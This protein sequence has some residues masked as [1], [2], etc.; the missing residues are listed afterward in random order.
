MMRDSH[1]KALV[2]P[3]N[4][5]KQVAKANR[6]KLA[7]HSDEIQFLAD[8]INYQQDL[9]NKQATIINTL[10]GST[11]GTGTSGTIETKE[12]TTTTKKKKSS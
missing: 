9:I 11:S 7:H 8:C 4:P 1:S 6:K 5:E 10:T 3:A 2:F 12:E